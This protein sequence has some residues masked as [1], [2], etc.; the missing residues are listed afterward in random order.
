MLASPPH[1]ALSAV[2]LG[3]KKNSSSGTS[4]IIT[5]VFLVGIF[6]VV[7]AVRRS[8]ARVAHKTAEPLTPGSE[9]V[10]RAGMFG[11]VREVSPDELAVEVAPGVIVRMLPNAVF[12]R[13]QLENQDR[14]R[15]R[16]TLGQQPSDPA[17]G[18]ASTETSATDDGSP[19][20]P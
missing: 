2:V 8:R 20:E 16:R 13:T 18:T 3:A 11:T 15:G 14:S 1:Y 19:T 17:N 4:L 5:V 7:T 10:T 6:L 12:S 9:V